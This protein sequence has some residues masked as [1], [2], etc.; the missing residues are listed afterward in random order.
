MSSWSERQ[1]DVS[2][3][4]HK[5][6]RATVFKVKFLLLMATL[7]RA[8]TPISQ[9]RTPWFQ[10]ARAEL[11]QEPLHPGNLLDSGAICQARAL[12]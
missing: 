4:S 11:G 5:C 2:Y 9:Q 6:K 12:N 1:S 8:A 10:E 3:A 7:G